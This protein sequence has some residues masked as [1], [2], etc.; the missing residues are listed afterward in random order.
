MD[1]VESIL[2]LHR[3]GIPS[4]ATRQSNESDAWIPAKP[5]YLTWANLGIVASGSTSVSSWNML[6]FSINVSRFGMYCSR[7]SAIRLEEQIFSLTSF[8]MRN[9][10]G[11]ELVAYVIWLLARYNVFSL[12]KKG[13]PSSLRMSLLVK[14]MVSNWFNVAPRFSIA[15]IFNSEQSQVCIS[16]MNRFEITS[17][18]EF[19]LTDRIEILR[20]GFNRF[21][22]KTT[23][24]QLE[25]LFDKRKKSI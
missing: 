12:G 23:H 4:K 25:L 14:S 1:N 17:Q 3:N 6:L 5:S 24:V 19:V 11:G 22:S 7:L 15:G 21:R 16:G 18:T 9:V 10:N 8:S 20:S 2:F 13:N